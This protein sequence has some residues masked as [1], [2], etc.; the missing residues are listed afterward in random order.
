MESARR[1]LFA[2]TFLFFLIS[3]FYILKLRSDTRVTRVEEGQSIFV[4]IKDCHEKTKVLEFEQQA[5]IKD[6]VKFTDCAIDN[7]DR[8]GLEELVRSG[9]R[10]TI[11]T[12]G[13]INKSRMAGA[14][15]YAMGIRFSLNEASADELALLPGIGPELAVRI[16]EA[17]DQQGRFRDFEELLKVKGIGRKKLAVLKEYTTIE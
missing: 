15:L 1:T 9:D 8:D 7:S 3:L 11:D 13:Q 6:L 16:I 2:L 14:K 10:I 12:K 17:R 5:K 4:E